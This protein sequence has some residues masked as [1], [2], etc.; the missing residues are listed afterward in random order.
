MS[1]GKQRQKALKIIGPGQIAVEAAAQ[2]PRLE[3]DEVLIRVAAVAINPFD[4]K[5]AD[6][7]PS[8]GATIGCDYAGTVHSIS[9]KAKT[10]L[11][12]GDRVCGWVFGNNPDR[13]DNGAF[14]EFTAAP[15][16]LLM[17][18]PEDMSFEEAATLGVGIATAGMVLYHTMQLPLPLATESNKE[19]VLV[20]GGATATGIIA[21]QLLRL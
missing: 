5:S 14:A 11:R 3:D 13:L 10:E 20:N 16:D 12:I 19:F 18:I 2:I 4:S 21:I 6:L 9:S 1:I 7:S 8:I 17:R 15:A